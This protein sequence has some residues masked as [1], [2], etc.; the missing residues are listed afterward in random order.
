MNVILISV[1]DVFERPSRYLI[2]SGRNKKPLPQKRISCTPYFCSFANPRALSA[3]EAAFANKL[4]C[5]D[6]VIVT[7]KLVEPSAFQDWT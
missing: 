2:A 5:I 3:F 6:E 1:L 7:S 4:G